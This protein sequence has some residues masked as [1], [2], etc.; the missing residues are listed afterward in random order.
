MQVM[1]GG[2][3]HEGAANGP[4][5]RCT[6]P[7]AD[8]QPPDSRM[9]AGPLSGPGERRDNHPVPEDCG[10]SN[11][12]HRD[13]GHRGLPGGVRAGKRSA[14][15]SSAVV[16]P[17]PGSPSLQS[18]P[19]SASASTSTRPSG[20]PITTPGA[21]SMPRSSRKTPASR[22]P[23]TAKRF[24]LTGMARPRGRAP[25]DHPHRHTTAFLQSC[26]RYRHRRRCRALG[27]DTAL[28]GVRN[29]LGC[30]HA[31]R[32]CS[33]SRSPDQAARLA[34]AQGRPPHKS[35]ATHVAPSRQ[36]PSSPAHKPRVT[37][38]RATAPSSGYRQPQL[39]R[40]LDHEHEAGTRA[41]IGAGIA[42]VD[43]VIILP[44]TCWSMGG[45][46]VGGPEPRVSARARAEPV[47]APWL[48]TVPQSGRTCHGSVLIARRRSGPTTVGATCGPRVP[49]S[50]TSGSG[51]SAGLSASWCKSS[52]PASRTSYLRRSVPRL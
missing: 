20:W 36:D 44:R 11:L 27:S 51:L 25:G 28:V 15:S 10:V 22:C 35:L 18:D 6:L 7:L 31:R 45:S 21:S 30:G 24:T 37:H 26:T 17:A 33:W 3:A 5:E 41:G 46:G 50:D 1:A 52:R 16:F 48:T 13:E 49:S 40:L 47:T 38:T 19:S 2:G 32:A 34:G 43:S 39:S 14:T 8:G 9:A 42:A 12:G 23:G 4:A 29:L